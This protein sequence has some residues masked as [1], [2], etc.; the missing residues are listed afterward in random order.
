[1]TTITKSS[2][3]TAPVSAVIPVK[4][5]K[6]AREFY[7]SVLGLEIDSME[8]P[9]GVLVHGGEGTRF[10][11]YETS[12]TSSATVASFLV[13][14]LRSVVSELRARGV[15]FAEYDMPG[16]KTVGGIADLGPGGLSAWITDSEG[17]AVGIVQM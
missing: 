5:L 10:L 9:G 7:E 17:N 6:R 1:M 16:L 15:T 13:K 4:D 14:D 12:A 3:A 8:I 11:L 2:L